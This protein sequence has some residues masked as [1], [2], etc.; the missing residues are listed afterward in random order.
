VTCW[1]AILVEAV[2]NL[3]VCGAASA[4]ALAFILKFAL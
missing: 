1:F 4:Y 2:Y 3:F